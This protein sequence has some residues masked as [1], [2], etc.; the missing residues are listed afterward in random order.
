MQCSF[1]QFTVWIYR[2]I[3]SSQ[4]IA[5]RVRVEVTGSFLS[6]VSL[7]GEARDRKKANSKPQMAR[8][9]TQHPACSSQHRQSVFRLFECWGLVKHFTK[10]PLSAQT[11]QF[12]LQNIVRF[13]QSRFSLSE[14]ASKQ[15]SILQVS[16]HGFLPA[17]G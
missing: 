10:G 17:D 6:W 4:N 7:I 9:K 15:A 5:A 8:T 2:Q 13:P 11:L 16:S 12:G 3:L 1:Q 14:K